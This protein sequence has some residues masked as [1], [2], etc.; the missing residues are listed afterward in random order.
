MSKREV[1]KLLTGLITLLIIIV[2]AISVTSICIFSYIV[3]TKYVL[4]FD[5][6]I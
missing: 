3:Y 2:G 5:I 1:K 4:A 6:M